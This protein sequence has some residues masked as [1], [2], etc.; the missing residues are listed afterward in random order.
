[1]SSELFGSFHGFDGVCVCVLYCVHKQTNHHIFMTF[2]ILNSQNLI[3]FNAC[4]DAIWKLINVFVAIALG[5]DNTGDV[6]PRCWIVKVAWKN[7][8]II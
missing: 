2:L 6:E 3:I 1:M 4:N 7:S 8:E 5:P